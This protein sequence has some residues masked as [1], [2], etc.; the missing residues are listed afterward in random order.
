MVKVINDSNIDSIPLSGKDSIPFHSIIV[1]EEKSLPK[2]Q[3]S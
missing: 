3:L 2:S 1:P